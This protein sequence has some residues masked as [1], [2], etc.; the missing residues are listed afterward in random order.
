MRDDTRSILRERRRRYHALPPLSHLCSLWRLLRRGDA[1]CYGIAHLVQSHARTARLRPSL[2]TQAVRLGAGRR[3]PVRPGRH[4]GRFARH[5]VVRRRRGA[6][7]RG[8]EVSPQGRAAHPTGHQLRK[9]RPERT[10]AGR[11]AGRHLA[12]SRSR[13]RRAHGWGVRRDRR[14]LDHGLSLVGRTAR[15][16]RGGAAARARRRAPA[17]ALD[18]GVPR[19]ARRLADELDGKHPLRGRRAGRLDPRASTGHRADGARPPVTVPDGRLLGGSHRRH[20]GVQC[21]GLMAPDLRT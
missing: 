13:S 11:R 1:S 12:R 21:G 7:R 17:A 20:V 14:R 16:R 15:P 3:R 10:R 18:L 5:L 4:R 8:L 19:P 2:R 9:P 6:D